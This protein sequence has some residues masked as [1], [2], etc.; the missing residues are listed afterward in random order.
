MSHASKQ[1]SLHAASQ[2][3]NSNINAQGFSNMTTSTAS[4]SRT[5]NLQN[6]ATGQ[7][8]SGNTRV[9]TMI[10]QHEKPM[11]GNGT[12]TNGNIQIQ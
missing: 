11:G 5:A 12:A 2:S 6:A 7:G 9:R 1:Q 8:P 4:V 3:M 10:N